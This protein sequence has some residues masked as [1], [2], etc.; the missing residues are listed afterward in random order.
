MTALR[1]LTLLA[2]AMLN[3]WLHFGHA[4]S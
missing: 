2:Y 4:S 3:N 1:K